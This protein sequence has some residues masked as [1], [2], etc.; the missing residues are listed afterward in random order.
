MLLANIPLIPYREQK[1]VEPDGGLKVLQE[2]NE[3]L[4][5]ASFNASHDELGQV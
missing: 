4:F 5:G 2:S 1:V 3:L